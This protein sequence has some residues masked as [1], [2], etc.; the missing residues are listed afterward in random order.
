MDSTFM[1]LARNAA[2]LAALGLAAVYAIGAYL[3]TTELRG[4]HVDPR[5]V[6]PLIPVEQLLSRGIVTLALSA[7]LAKPRRHAR[8]AGRSQ[9]I[10]A[11]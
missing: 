5:E 3:K 7:L 4:A 8:A 11:A 6:L 1:R 2:A 10:F 9:A